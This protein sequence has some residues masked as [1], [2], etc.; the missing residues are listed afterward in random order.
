ML[1]EMRKLPTTLT[2]ILSCLFE[3]DET[4]DWIFTVTDDNALQMLLGIQIVELRELKIVGDLDGFVVVLCLFVPHVL[5]FG[6]G[7]NDF[8]SE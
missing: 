7:V 6:R 3:N 8:E 4:N 1:R 5:D 2:T